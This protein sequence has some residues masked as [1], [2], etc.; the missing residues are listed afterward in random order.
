M[1]AF[2][3]DVHRRLGSLTMVWN[4]NQIHSKAKVVKGW[5]ASR[6]DVVAEHFPG[7]VPDR[8]PDEGVWGGSSMLGWRTWQPPT[9]TRCENG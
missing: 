4:R 3:A 7:Y 5:L 2:L 8:N 1:V 6:P 9:S